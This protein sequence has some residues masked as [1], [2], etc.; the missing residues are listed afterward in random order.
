VA[1][2]RGLI[3]VG[4][5]V[6]PEWD[7]AE[8]FA[9]PQVGRRGVDRIAAQDE[10]HVHLAGVHVVGELAERLCLVD[11]GRLHRV[12]EHDRA[13][14]AAEGVVHRM[15]ER[16]NDRRLALA[17][18]HQ[19]RALVGLEIPGHCLRETADAVRERRTRP[20][21]TRHTHGLR[22]LP[23]RR[24]NLTGPHRQTMIGARPG[25]GRHA[26]DRVQPVHA[27]RLLRSPARREGARIPQRPGAAAQE[28]GVEGEDDVRVLN[29]V[30]R[31]D[32]L[33]EGELRAQACVVAAR[34][35]PLV[36][37][38]GRQPP[39]QLLQLRRQRRGADRLR[40][41]AESGA[42]QRLLSH[43]C[44]AQRADERRPRTDL[45][46]V[47]HRT[48]T[49]RIVQ[50]E[51]RRLREH[52]AGAEAVRVER[53]ALDLR[54]AAFVT[55]DQQTRSDTADGHRCGVV[56]RPAGHHF[57]GL[58][59][60]GHDCLERLAGAGGDAGEAER[61]AHQLEERA[62]CH[63]IG[64]RFD[65]GRELVVQPL[66]KCRI[67]GLFLERP[68]PFRPVPHAGGE[69]GAAARHAAVRSRAHA[70][71]AHW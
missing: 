38:G 2:L 19:R 54:G 14:D 5:E 61:G 23:R 66:L 32:E 7:L 49:I 34:G 24:F 11:R 63:R 36:P 68:P 62:P 16:V 37:P 17:R 26:L 69:G 8:R 55:L 45:A 15:S 48:R 22:H 30:L 20:A 58:P 43:Q 50:A 64:D 44:G 70:V 9:E 28:V 52:V 13:A 46:Q 59:H 39:E 33:A 3:V 6:D 1:Q 60:V 65:F 29:A 27:I 47:R 41:N 25:R 71:T 31:L 53:I 57:L 51:D 12:G 67:V 35:I 42:L 4:A 40:Q 21:R 18:N 56:Q 10:Q